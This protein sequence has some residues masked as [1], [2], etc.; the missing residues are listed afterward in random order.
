MKKNKRRKWE[1]NESYFEIAEIWSFQR[2]IFQDIQKENERKSGEAY[3]VV[4][5]KRSWAER[6][7]SKA[8]EWRLE[9][10]G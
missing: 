2:V 10:R 5:A 6:N 8:G 1:R 9:R 3:R 7:D 4:E